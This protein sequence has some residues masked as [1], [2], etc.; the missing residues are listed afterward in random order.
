MF[1]KII[2]DVQIRKNIHRMKKEQA[3][4]TYP[5]SQLFL[6][7]YIKYITEGNIQYYYKH[8]DC[9]LANASHLNLNNVNT[10]QRITGENLT[11][12]KIPF[13]FNQN[14]TILDNYTTYTI[15]PEA[16]DIFTP[17]LCLKETP[18]IQMLTLK[19]IKRKIDNYNAGN[20]EVA[21][22]NAH[23]NH[24]EP[25]IFEISNQYKIK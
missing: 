22:F 13:N 7:Y 4:T 10:L 24:T 20:K 12:S 1:N 18:K 14:T 23:Q 17:P 3:N 5:S 11:Q 8:Y 16:H 9:F 15:S 25:P 2:Q 21:C 6:G 19:Q